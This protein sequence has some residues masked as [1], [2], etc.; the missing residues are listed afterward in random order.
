MC[1]LSCIRTLMALRKGSEGRELQ[2][3]IGTEDG[4]GPKIRK[5][6]GVYCSVE[7]GCVERGRE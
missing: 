3:Q 5:N 4:S 2:S 7:V 1:L 6:E